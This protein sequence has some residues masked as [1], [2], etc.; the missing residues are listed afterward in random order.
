MNKIYLIFIYPVD[1]V[2][3]VKN[4]IKRHFFS[5]EIYGSVRPYA[6]LLP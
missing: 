1:P 4:L 5:I 2:D 3:P 6:V